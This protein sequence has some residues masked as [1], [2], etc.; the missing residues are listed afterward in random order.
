MPNSGLDIEGREKRR[1][2]L[3]QYQYDMEREEGR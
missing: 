2:V 3:Q 1:I